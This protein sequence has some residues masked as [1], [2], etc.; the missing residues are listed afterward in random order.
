MIKRK[1]IWMCSLMVLLGFVYIFFE[2]VESSKFGSFDILALEQLEEL[3]D[4]KSYVE[5][6]LNIDDILTLRGQNPAYDEKSNTFYVGHLASERDFLSHFETKNAGYRLYIEKMDDLDNVSELMRDGKQARLWII[7]ESAYSICNIIFSGVPIIKIDTDESIRSEYGMGNV[8]LFEPNDD[9]VNKQNIKSAYVLAKKNMNSQTYS[10]RLMNKEYDDEKK[11]DLLGTGKYSDWKLYRVSESDGSLMQAKLASDLWN[12]INKE[13]K[14]TRVYSFVEVIENN[15]YKGVYLMTPKWTKSTVELNDNDM[16][17]QS[18]DVGLDQAMLLNEQMSSECIS[19][20]ALFLQLTYAYNNI[21]DDCIYIKRLM[22]DNSI[23]YTIIPN[24]IE[25]ALG[26]F[27]KTLHYLTWQDTS[28]MFLEAEDFSVSQERWNKEIY[29]LCS[30]KWK[31]LRDG[32]I[33]IDTVLHIM[34]EYKAYLIN[35]GLAKRCVDAD[36]FGYHYDRLE[37]YVVKRISFLDEYYAY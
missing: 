20:Y 27:D 11:I 34:Q 13:K 36:S 2:L 8:V 12:I 25:Y 31:E 9:A 18:E 17:V 30:A 23:Q 24:K 14:I 37:D 32:N 26:G 7:S 22:P 6:P 35:T 21:G 28:R 4:G 16:M 5:K 3:T 10:L 29:P 15:D 1:S 19:D 33:D